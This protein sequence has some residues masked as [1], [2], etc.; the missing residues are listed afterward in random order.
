VTWPIGLGA[1]G[2]SAVLSTVKQTPGTIGYLELS[3]A[4]QNGV[5][6]ASIQ[7][8][9]GAFIEPTPTSAAAAIAAFES[10]LAHDVRSPIV[11]PPASA[12]A[13]YPIAG[14]TFLLLSK[15]RADRNEQVAVKDFVAYTISTGQESAERLSYATL[16]PFLQQQGQALLAQLTANGQPL[17]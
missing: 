4:K 13:A 17:K 9:A 7:N 15:D 14:I 1:D 3:Y 8:G 12:K 2:S 10:D 16:P 6:V 5:P 11:D